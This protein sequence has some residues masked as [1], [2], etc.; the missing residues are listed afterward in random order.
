MATRTTTQTV[1]TIPHQFGNVRQRQVYTDGFNG[2]RPLVPASSKLLELQAK[3]RMSPDA[4]GYLSG[5]DETMEANIAAFRHWSIVPRILRNVAQRDLSVQLFGQTLPVPFLL[6]PIGVQKIVHPDGEGAVARAAA[7][8]GVPMIPS[9]AAYITL[10]DLAKT[11]GDTPRW[12]QLYWSKDPDFNASL[13]RRAERAGYTA[14]V[15]TL[16]TYYL[17]WRVDDIQNAYMPFPLYDGL[18]NYLTDPVFRRSLK[19]PPEKDRHAAIQLYMEIFGNP[20]LTWADIP[21][22]RQHTKLPILLKGIMH[23]DD[24]RQAVEAGIDGIIVSNHGGRQV[25]GERAAIDALPDI[26]EAVKGQV[27]LLFDSGIRKAA[28]AFKAIALG[29]KA[30]LLGR[31]YL[32]GLALA[33]EQGVEEVLQNFIADLDLTLALSGHTAYS[34]LDVSA[35]HK[36]PV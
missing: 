12:F 13:L 3:E 28:D 22:L 35:L 11:L 32:W 16:D 31:P 36:E 10:E 18:V 8:L 15:V 21:F 34:A 25:N 20:S 7:K 4:W 2:R 14:I 27:P 19:Q 1:A 29:A 30:V 33:G 5:M 23:P 17:G 9:T 24:A 26:V 6:A